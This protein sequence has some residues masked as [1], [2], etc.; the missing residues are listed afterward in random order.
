MVQSNPTDKFERKLIK[1][2][3]FFTPRPIYLYYFKICVCV[4]M[5]KSMGV[6]VQYYLNAKWYG[7][8]IGTKWN[9]WK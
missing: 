3:L 1:I 2:L 7:Y 6:P 8:H 4:H 5:C 9:G